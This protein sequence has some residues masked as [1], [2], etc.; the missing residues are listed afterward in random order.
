MQQLSH[1]FLLAIEIHGGDFLFDLEIFHGRS[2][3]DY[4]FLNGTNRLNDGE[5]RCGNDLDD[6]FVK[7]IAIVEDDNI[8][9][10][11]IEE[12]DIISDFRHQIDLP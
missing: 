5:P 10:F 7:D 8:I 2:G 11:C 3:L 9:V 12:H 6:V 1:L 4:A